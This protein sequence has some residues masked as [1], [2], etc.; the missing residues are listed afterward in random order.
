[1][2]SP[3]SCASHARELEMDGLIWLFLSPKRGDSE[4][5][6]SKQRKGPRERVHIY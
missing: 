5:S 3:K 4:P 6:I 1:M 2:S